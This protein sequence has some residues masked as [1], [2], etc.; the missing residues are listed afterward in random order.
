MKHIINQFLNKY[1]WIR[2]INQNYIE[3]KLL[4]GGWEFS[5]KQKEIG[6]HYIVLQTSIK[7]NSRWQFWKNE[8]QI[9]WKFVFTDQVVSFGCKNVSGIRWG[10]M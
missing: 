9:D 7:I 2:D 4:G 8:R 1:I 3:G 5:D 10:Y 6:R